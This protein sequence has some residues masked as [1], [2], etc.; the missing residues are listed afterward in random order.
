M[1]SSN[2][3]EHWG[4]GGGGLQHLVELLLAATESPAWPSR[5]AFAAPSAERLQQTGE[6]VELQLLLLLLALALSD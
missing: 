2:I 3:I 5:L 4:G 6:L 1:Q